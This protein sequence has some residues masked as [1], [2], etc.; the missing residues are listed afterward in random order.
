ML[1]LILILPDKLAG[2]GTSWLLAREGTAG[3][4]A[5]GSLSFTAA[6]QSPEGYSDSSACRAVLACQALW[7]EWTQGTSDAVF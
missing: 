5:R 1:M 3:T 4:P 6:P 7:H 2:H